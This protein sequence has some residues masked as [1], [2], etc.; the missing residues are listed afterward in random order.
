ME[1]DHGGDPAV[2]GIVHRK[3]ECRCMNVI[4]SHPQVNGHGMTRA[5][6]MMAAAQ[7]RIEV[8]RD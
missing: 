1:I 8:A 6:V 7:S 2:M 4:R 5:K 3:S